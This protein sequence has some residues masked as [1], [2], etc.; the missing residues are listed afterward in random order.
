[1]FGS[2]GGGLRPSP[3]ESVRPSRTLRVRSGLR[4]P[5]QADA[6]GRSVER[7]KPLYA[8][9]ELIRAGTAEGR[10]RANRRASRPSSE[11]T[12]REARRRPRSPARAAPSRSL[13]P[14]GRRAQILALQIRE[15]RLRVDRRA[16]RAAQQLL[17][18]VLAAAPVHVLL[19][20][21]AQRAE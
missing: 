20:P 18:R 19:Q 2:G 13:V 10:H 14:D 8:E 11:Q 15:I 3:P 1:M 12:L 21:A 16:D 4:R 6:K 9:A 17:R 5:C 7:A